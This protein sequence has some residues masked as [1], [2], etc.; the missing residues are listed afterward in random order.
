MAKIAYRLSEEAYA[1]AREV[2]AKLIVLQSVDKLPAIAKSNLRSLRKVL[3][4][5]DKVLKDLE[6]KH[7]LRF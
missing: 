2:L 7:D 1:L 4:E 5:I 6:T 3:D